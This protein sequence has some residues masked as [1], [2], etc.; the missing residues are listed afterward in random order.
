MSMEAGMQGGQPQ[1]INIYSS[2]LWQETRPPKGTRCVCELPEPAAPRNSSPRKAWM[3]GG[4]LTEGE[5]KA[6]GE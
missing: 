3:E 1:H 5:R 2:Y 4:L 6:R